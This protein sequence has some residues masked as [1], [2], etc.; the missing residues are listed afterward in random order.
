ME[1]SLMHGYTGPRILN[2]DV[3]T[4]HASIESMPE[5]FVRTWMGANGFAARLLFDRVKPGTDPLSEDNLFVLAVGPVTDAVIGSARGYIAFKSPLTGLYCDATFGGRFAVTQKRTGFECI[6]IS[7]CADRP[8]IVVVDENGATIEDAGDLWGKGAAETVTRLGERFG[9]GADAVAIGPAGEAGVRYACVSHYWKS[10]QGI[11]GRGGGGGVLGSKNVKAVV[12]TGS[13][14]TRVADPKGLAAFVAD[15]TPGM[16]EKAAALTQYG[17]PVLTEMINKMGALAARNNQREFTDDVTPAGTDAFARLYQR[18]IA[19]FKCPIACGKL[20]KITDGPFAGLETKVVEYESIY[21][22]GAM[23]DCFD[24]AFLLHV[25]HMCDDLG[26]DTISIGVTLAFAAECLEKGLLCAS[27]VGYDAVF[28]N[29]DAILSLIAD[30]ASMTGF[31]ERLAQGSVRMADAIGGDAPQFLYAVK[32]ME[33][34]GHSPRALKGLGLGYA[35]GT[36]GGSHHD[37]RPSTMYPADHDNTSI[38]GQAQLSFDSQNMSALGDSL[39]LC[40]FL[41]ERL[42]GHRI[43]ES[44]A[45]LLHLVTGWDIDVAEAAAMGERMVNMERCFNVREGVDVSR[46]TLPHRVMNEPIP[47]GALAGQCC[48]EEELA[49]MRAEYYAIRGWD[50]RGIPTHETLD[51]LGIGDAFEQLPR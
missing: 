26:V 47:N 22:L 12:V 11:A 21:A 51:R 3:S 33:I 41:S 42:L 49:T 18:N 36:R 38:D 6:A 37:T 20:C 8:V 9:A 4:G 23:L 45:T 44:F 46:D 10:R 34:A 32:G 28:G 29:T 31:G 25:N 27:D 15:G 24:P 16:L 39:T 1:T 50:A 35:T 19:C 30:T 7:G 40:R 43:N 2:L 13:R 5:T 14:K 48:T 17:T